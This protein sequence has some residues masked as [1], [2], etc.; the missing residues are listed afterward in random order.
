MRP[1]AWFHSGDTVTVTVRAT[2]RGG[3]DAID[4]LVELSDGRLALKA[5]VSVAAED[6]KANAALVRLLAKAAGIASSNVELA[7][8]AT[9]RLKTFRLTGD[10]ALILARLE[11]IVADKG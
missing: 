5:R 10:A 6:G 8:G 7:S 9:G 11:A 1:A 4:G 3:R 2:P